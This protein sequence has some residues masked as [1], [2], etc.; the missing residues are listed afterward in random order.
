MNKIE[1]LSLAKKEQKLLSKKIKKLE[2]SILEGGVDRCALG[3]EIENTRWPKRVICQ[4]DALK[5]EYYLGLDDEDFGDYYAR[6]T[7]YCKE[8][9]Q[10]HGKKLLALEKIWEEAIRYFA[11]SSEEV[12][13]KKWSEKAQKARDEYRALSRTLWE[14]ES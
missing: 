13:L 10:E 3:F 11:Q 5:N 8:I 4:K 12:P 2:N 14:K 1:Q 9:P 7:A 6:K